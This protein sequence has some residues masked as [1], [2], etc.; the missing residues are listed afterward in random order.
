MADSSGRDALGDLAAA[1]HE[2]HVVV[3]GAGIAGLV[4]ALECAKFGLRVTLVEASG[5]PRRHPRADRRR[6][7]PT[8]RRRRRVVDTRRRGAGARRRARARGRRSCPPQTPPTWIS[9]LRSGAAPLPAATIAGIPQNPWDESVREDHR[10][11]RR[12]ARLPRPCPAAA[13]DRQGAQP[14]QA[15]PHAHGRRRARATR[16]AGEPGRL[17]HAPRRHRRRS[18]RARAQ[19]RTHPHRLAERRGRRPARRPI[20]GPALETIDG[21]MLRLVR[22]AESRLV[23]LG[24]DIR[25]GAPVDSLDRLDDERWAVALG[26]AEAAPVDPADHVIIATPEAPARAL[27]GPLAR[28]APA[29][30]APSGAARRRDPRGPRSLAGWG[31]ARRRG[32]PGRRHLSRRRPHPLHRAVAV[33][34][35]DRRAGGS[36]AAGGA[37]ARAARRRR[38]RRW[39]TPQRRH[40]PARRH[41]LCWRCRSPTC[42][43]LRGCD[44]SRRPRRPRSGTRRRP[45]RRVRRSAPW[46]GSPPSAD[47]WRDRVSRRWCRMP[48]PAADDA[49]RHALWGETSA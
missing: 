30:R 44:C 49:R 42:S 6:R 26:S 15:R 24:A 17:R 10:L 25:V 22:A 41:P 2:R 13:D 21:G 23:E 31:T 35:G 48:S 32:L 1:A 29:D 38:R 20:S 19:H 9:G 47:G 40:S 8:R 7:A 46:Q 16:R 39:T 18:G 27:L 11:G 28:R 45:R 5:S 33:A 12:V 37:S 43:G 34:R 3:V 36:R 4:A 14:R